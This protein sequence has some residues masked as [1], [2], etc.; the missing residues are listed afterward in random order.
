[1]KSR[2]FW[3]DRVESAWEERPIVWLSGIRRVG[4]TFL[5]SSLNNM[6]YFD[7]EL[8]SLRAQL[9][10]PEFFFEQLDGKRIVLDEIHRL[11]NPSEVLKIAAD[12]Y[13]NVK[14]LA[15]GS[16]SLSASKKFSD[17]LTGRKSEIWLTPML[18][19]EASVFGNTDIKHR[20]NVRRV[21]K[22]LYVS[23]FS[24]KKL[25]RVARFILG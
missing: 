6:E 19:H 11:S 7:C 20:L 2:L 5:G 21:T 10:D 24:R 17:T 1:M 23:R 12:H 22:F 3:Q 14:V 15:T 16:S 8:P 25:S 18:F 13:P 4:K 9:D